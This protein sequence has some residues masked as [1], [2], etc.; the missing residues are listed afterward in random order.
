[1]PRVDRLEKEKM[2]SLKRTGSKKER[3]VEINCYL[4]AGQQRSRISGRPAEPFC[5][6]QS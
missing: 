4:L 6:A 5:L 1:M 3:V 2:V